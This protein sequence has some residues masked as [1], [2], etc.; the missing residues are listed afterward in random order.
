MVTSGWW[1]LHCWAVVMP[2]SGLAAWRAG[3]AGVGAGAAAA[4][5]SAQAWA[6][7]G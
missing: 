6:A 3:P 5:T 1:S 7:A 4:S 2:L